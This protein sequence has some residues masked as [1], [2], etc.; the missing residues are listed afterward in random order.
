MKDEKRLRIEGECGKLPLLFAKYADSGDYDAIAGLFAED[1]VYARP[2]QPHVEHRGRDTVRAMFRD[3]PPIL[4]RHV[5]SNVLVEVI[6]DKEA[7]GTNYVTMLSNHASTEP[8][9]EAGG[10]YVGEFTDH[11][12]TTR[13]GWEFQSR[14]G[15]IALTQGVPKPK[16]ASKAA[17]AKAKGAKK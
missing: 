9:Q 6:S 11:Y 17:P 14:R 8:P 12:V 3:R 7:R 4:V 2:F 10:I 13:H 1:C 5:V 15:V 16:A